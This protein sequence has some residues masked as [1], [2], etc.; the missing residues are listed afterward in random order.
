M[1]P[2]CDRRSRACA[3]TALPA[4]ASSRS[5]SCGDFESSSTSGPAGTRAIRV[6]TGA[7]AAQPR[8][9]DQE[10][11]VLGG[12]SPLRRRR[13]HVARTRSS[14]SGSGRA[15]SWWCHPLSNGGCR[16]DRLNGLDRTAREDTLAQCQPQADPTA[17]PRP[18][19][20]YGFSMA[21]CAGPLEPACGR[22]N[23]RVSPE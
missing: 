5:R 19:S 2:D 7:M 3:I 14:S 6:D 11:T 9:F 12:S 23:S 1:V 15:R 20:R 21:P 18:R 4:C 10:R 22:S 17:S 13:S 16:S 8:V